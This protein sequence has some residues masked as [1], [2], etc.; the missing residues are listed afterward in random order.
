MARTK[1]TTRQNNTII[2]PATSV[3]DSRDVPASSKQT[4]S[5][6]RIAFDRS[7]TTPNTN[8]AV[9]GQDIVKS[10]RVDQL[11]TTNPS[12]IATYINDLETANAVMSNK[13]RQTE[14]SNS[15]MIKRL[16][17][18]E[19][20]IELAKTSVENHLEDLKS[21]GVPPKLVERVHRPN[22]LRN[23]MHRARFDEFS[24]QMLVNSGQAAKQQVD[25]HEQ[26]N[27]SNGQKIDQ[28]GRVSKKRKRIYDRSD[29][30]D[31]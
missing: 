19:F 13:L 26:H 30:S 9:A 11:L 1:Q 14:K 15:S 16:K 28:D 5:Q 6:D 23:N 4:L 31:D 27:G 29:E 18:L 22:L 7:I 10:E 17:H 25:Q 12:A 8:V 20:A 2:S 3:N 21:E 24:D